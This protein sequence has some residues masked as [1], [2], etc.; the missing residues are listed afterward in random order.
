MVLPTEFQ[1]QALNE[2]AV[3]I[4]GARTR[5]EDPNKKINKEPRQDKKRAA[6]K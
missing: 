1:S 3:K 2:K 5:L 4:N 6:R